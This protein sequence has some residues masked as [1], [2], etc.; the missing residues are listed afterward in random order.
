[1]TAGRWADPVDVGIYATKREENPAPF[2]ALT[3]VGL[4]DKI[5]VG[6]AIIAGLSIFMSSISSGDSC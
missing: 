5:R 4:I 2:S 3:K 1:M 6:L